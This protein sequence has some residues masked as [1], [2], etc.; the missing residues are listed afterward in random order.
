ME[1]FIV[2]ESILEKAI[3]DE[4]I[5]YGI[6]SN[7]LKHWTILDALREIYQNF[8]DYGIYTTYIKDDIINADNFIIK[9][10]ND[11][12]PDNLEFLII[13]NSNKDDNSIGKYGEGLKMAMLIFLR[14][15]YDIS[16]ITNNTVIF[17]KFKTISNIGEVLTI[18]K[19]AIKESIGFSIEFNISKDTYNK[20]ISNLITEAD[21]IFRDKYFGEIVNKEKGNIYSGNLYVTHLAN[22]Q[23]SYN[24][25]PSELPL[26]RDRSVPRAFDVTWASSKI[27]EAYIKHI[28]KLN[29]S[30]IIYDDS[31]YLNYVPDSFKKEVK[32]K[33]INNEIIL[34][35]TDENK[36]DT[37]IENNNIK[38]IILSD[39]IFIRFIRILKHYTMKKLGI[40]DML[41]AYQNKYPMYGEAKQ[42]FDLILENVK[43][44]KLNN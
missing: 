23:Y 6:N 33:F 41:I 4:V 13:G 24:I 5:S 44:S 35:H 20:F 3:Y 32:P 43:R 25:K 34:V 40:Y 21:V 2:N 37:I 29:A 22:L 19:Y 42:D 36:N 27:K 8:I 7:Y 15:S 30:D 26:D 16:I 1:D 38:K 9:L 17:P 39:N 14:E 11:Y 10:S 12:I 31:L 18:Y 28:A